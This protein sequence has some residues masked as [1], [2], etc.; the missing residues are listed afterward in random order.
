MYFFFYYVSKSLH[1][2][3][4]CSWRGRGGLDTKSSIWLLIAC[5]L[6]RSTS[7]FS[8]TANFL[9]LHRH[10]NSEKN[11]MKPLLMVCAWCCYL[12]VW[13]SHPFSVMMLNAAVAHRPKVIRVSDSAFISQDI[14]LSSQQVVFIQLKG[15]QSLKSLH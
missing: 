6:L 15:L 8:C 4:L 14:K 2:K 1:V 12:L 13:R 10:C 5:A 11:C 3:F 9:N 7:S